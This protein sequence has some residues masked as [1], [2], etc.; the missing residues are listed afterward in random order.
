VLAVD[1]HAPSRAHVL[2]R[3]GNALIEHALPGGQR[4]RRRKMQE[5]DIVSSQLALVVTAFFAKIDHGTNAMRAGKLRNI[6]WRE[7]AA[8]GKLVRKPA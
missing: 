5:G 6:L 3:E 2:A 8:H 4:V 7:A 1:E